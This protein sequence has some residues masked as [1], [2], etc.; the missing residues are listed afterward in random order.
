ML[1]VSMAKD[2]REKLIPCMVRLTPE[3]MQK[4]RTLKGEG[5]SPAALVRRFVANGLTQMKV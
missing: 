3:Q 1:R 4:L 5:Y 2:T